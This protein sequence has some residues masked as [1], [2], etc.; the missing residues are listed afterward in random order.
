[1][2]PSTFSTASAPTIR[3]FRGSITRP[4]HSL[5]TLR[6][7]DHSTTTQDS[8]PAVASFTGQDASS[9]KVPTKGFSN[10]SHPPFPS[11]SWRKPGCPGRFPAPGSHRSGRAQLTH[12]ALHAMDSL[13]DGQ[14]LTDR[15]WVTHPWMK[16]ELAP[17]PLS[18]V[19][20]W[21][22]DRG[23]VSSPPFPSTVPSHDIPFPPQGLLGERFP[24]FLGTMECSDAR[25][26]LPTRFVAFACRYHPHTDVSLPSTLRSASKGRGLVV[27]LSPLRLT[28]EWKRSDLPSSWGTSM[29]VPCSQTPAGPLHQAI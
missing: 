4:V 10:P 28:V 22:R 1:M 29:H 15:V 7:M 14:T 20:S 9:C 11:F 24:C 19:V 8:L 3:F 25:S 6:R 26:L 2:R 17:V 27:P 12:P 5:S 21:R 23:P 13:R 18:V 16:P